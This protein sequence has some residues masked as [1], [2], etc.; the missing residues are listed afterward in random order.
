MKVLKDNKEIFILLIVAL[1]LFYLNKQN[2]NIEGY[3]NIWRQLANYFNEQ[4]T[5]CLIDNCV[6]PDKCPRSFILSSNRSLRRRCRCNNPRGFGNCFREKQINYNK[7]RNLLI[8]VNQISNI[9]KNIDQV[10][11]INNSKEKKQECEN[12]KNEVKDQIRSRFGDSSLD[13]TE[14]SDEKE[15][16]ESI[17]NTLNET[18][19]TCIDE[20]KEI[21]SESTNTINQLNQGMSNIMKNNL[22]SVLNVNESDLDQ[23]FQEKKAELLQINQEWREMGASS[24]WPPRRKSKRSRG[25]SRSRSRSR[26]RW[27]R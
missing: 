18:Y 26:R 21:K 2:N 7:L 13:G 27:R 24:W 19:G 23:E 25:R 15:E 1:V 14:L 10:T 3:A 9:Q 5:E 16:K 17:E 12:N 11:S 6:N 8:V 4:R 22:E 20:Y